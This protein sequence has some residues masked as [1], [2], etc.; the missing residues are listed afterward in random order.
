[1]PDFQC[2]EKIQFNITEQILSLKK[3]V[4]IP[5]LIDDVSC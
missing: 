1:M 3:T 5:D 2:H 4:T